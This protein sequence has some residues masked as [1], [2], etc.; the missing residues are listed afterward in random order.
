MNHWEEFVYGTT[1]KITRK[2]FRVTLNKAGIFLLN[3]NTF[4][5]LG[6]PEGVLLSYDRVNDMIG[7]KPM[8]R[9]F[10]TAF[11]VKITNRGHLIHASSFCRHFK[12]RVE[13]TIGWEPDGMD[14]NGRLCLDLKKAKSVVR[15]KGTSA[16]AK[17][18][19]SPG[20]EERIGR[21][22]VER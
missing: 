20:S 14:L 13:N 5:M 8:V 11:P 9:V 10:A 4:E 18:D 21:I 22:S 2:G 3:R 17:Q 15:A 12:L 7:I 16:I 19:P 1:V 6:K